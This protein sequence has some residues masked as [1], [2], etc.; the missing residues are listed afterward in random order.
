ML[1]APAGLGVREGILLAVLTPAISGGPA[2]LL[3][4]LSRL[5][6]TLLDVVLAGAGYLANR[7]L[8]NQSS[9]K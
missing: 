4:V 8:T 3:V 9:I 2:A 5:L 6:D 7:G 1:F